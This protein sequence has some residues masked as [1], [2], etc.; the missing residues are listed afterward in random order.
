MIRKIFYKFQKERD[1]TQGSIAKNIWILAVPMLISNGL[2]SAFNIVDMFW[3]GRLGPTALAAVAMSGSILM[4]VMFLMMGVSVGTT[5]MVAR[6]IGQK[7]KDEADHIAM[8]SLLMGFVLSLVLAVFGYFVSPWFLRLLGAAPEVVHLGSG[9]MQI[10]FLGVMVMFYMFLVSAILQGAG[11]ALT[12]MLILVIAT[13]INIVLDPLFI[14]GIGFFPRLGVNGAALA[15]VLAEAVG[16]L[17]ALEVLLRGRSRLQV[18][19]NDLKIDWHGMWRI[20]RI[21]MPAA[22]Q[23]SLRGLVGIVLMAVVSSFGTAAIAAYGVGLRLNMLALMPG[24]ALGMA[25]GTL[26]G[27][28]LGAKQLERSNTSA[29][30]AVFYYAIFMVILSILFISFAP[31]IILIFNNSPEVIRIGSLYLR[32]TAWGYV[33]V[34]L[35]IVLNR[36]LSG[37]GDTISPTIITF[38]S[39]WL[40]QIPLAIFL[41]KIPYLGVKGIW[42]AILIA[43]LVQGLLTAFWFQVGKWKHKPI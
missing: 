37:A 17:I 14:F 25:A 11:D 39:L 36:A 27:Q 12:P 32:I 23:M 6:F 29:W 9:Y 34:A 41:A 33:F 2:Q 30:T 18:R 8:Q 20:L 43:Y 24:F 40:F 19:I 10:L 16:S 28:N 35:G 38:V 5:A 1:L 42:Y 21:G 13:F 22:L 31:Q 26:V 3:V 7:R 4:I 15:T